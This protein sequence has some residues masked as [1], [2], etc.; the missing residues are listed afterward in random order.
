MKQK[1]QVECQAK[2]T[3]SATVPPS[4]GP[5]TGVA[6]VSFNRSLVS[7]IHTNPLSLH[8]FINPS[9][10]YKRDIETLFTSH[11]L[12]TPSTAVRYFR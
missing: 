4:Q 1:T 5:E 10:A 3:E 2:L 8:S 6:V 12:S 9:S 7:G 11:F